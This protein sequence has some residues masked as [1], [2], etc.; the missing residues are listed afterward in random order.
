MDAKSVL[1]D[2]QVT[3][4]LQYGP[5]SNKSKWPWNDYA[6]FT[7]IHC[8]I[9]SDLKVGVRDAPHTRHVSSTPLSVFVYHLTPTELKACIASCSIMVPVRLYRRF[10]SPAGPFIGWLDC[11]P[12]NTK[13]CGSWT[14][15]Q[16]TGLSVRKIVY[17]CSL[18]CY[19][20][21]FCS[22]LAD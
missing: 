20:V 7:D 18:F 22:L 19:F 11:L 8:G 10:R 12:K 17:R 13:R 4:A 16:L 9:P 14:G 21:D 5:R 1:Y 15:A 6:S 3:R 2:A